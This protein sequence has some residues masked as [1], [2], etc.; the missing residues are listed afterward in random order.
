[1]PDKPFKTCPNCRFVWPDRDAFLADAELTLIGYQANFRDLHEGILLFNHVCKGTLALPVSC[2]ADLYIG[3]VFQK[4][5]LETDK[6][7]GYCLHKTNLK[8]CPNE[9]EC[10]FVRQILSMLAPKREG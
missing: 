10:A 7:P 2:F 3:P 6:C 1:M 8:Q 4:R 5:M 9:C